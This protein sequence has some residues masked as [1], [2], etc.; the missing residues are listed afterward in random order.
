ML[1]VSFILGFFIGCLTM[2]SG[3][4]LVTLDKGERK[5]L[6]KEDWKIGYR[7]KH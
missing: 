7:R 5:N 6:A 1:F 3:I 2:M 4:A